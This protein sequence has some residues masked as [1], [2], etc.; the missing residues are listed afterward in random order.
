MPTLSDL[1][2]T[3]SWEQ[4]LDTLTM[5]TQEPRHRGY[6][7]NVWK[8]VK[9]LDPSK[10]SYKLLAIH[11]EWEDGDFVHVCGVNGKLGDDGTEVHW[12]I[13]SQPWN[14]W[15][16]MSIAPEGLAKVG[17]AEI[18]AA[19]LY[20]MSWD[21]QTQHQ[22]RKAALRMP[23]K[24]PKRVFL[25]YSHDDKAAIAEPLAR[26]LDAFGLEVWFDEFELLPGDSLRKS[27]ASGITKCNCAV[28]VLSRS[29]FRKAWTERELAGVISTEVSK[30]ILVIPILHNVSIKEV[31]A[32]DPSLADKLALSTDILRPDELAA[33]IH[34]AILVRVGKRR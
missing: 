13:S 3:V 9:F 12:N 5:R 29:Y 33:R 30:K 10:S 1:L 32:Y 27:I 18:V 14:E 11:T 34:E 4:V 23:G 16:G 31:T 15:V 25:S 24:R 21:G 28:I 26:E 7:Y 17:A 2:Q 8:R 6:F 22:V 20:E 19:S